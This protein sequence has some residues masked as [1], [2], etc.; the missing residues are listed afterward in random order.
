MDAFNSIASVKPSLVAKLIFLLGPIWPE[1]LSSLP[2]RRRQKTKAF[3][4]EVEKFAVSMLERQMAGKDAA[5]AEDLGQS[6]VG[7]VGE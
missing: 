6:I 4:K 1:L 3:S 7:S 5:A 2:N